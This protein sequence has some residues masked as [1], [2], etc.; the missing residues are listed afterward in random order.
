MSFNRGNSFGVHNDYYT[1]LSAWQDLAKVLRE[2]SVF[3]Q[4]P[5]KR[6][7][8]GDPV[9]PL[10]KLRVW[11]P[12]MLNSNGASKIH[13]ESLGFEVQGNVQ[14]DFFEL[15]SRP[16][17]KSYDLVISNPPFE[18]IRSFKRRHDNLKYKCIKGLLDIG[19]PFVL[20]INSLNVCSRW[21][22]E[23]VRGQEQHIRFIYPAKKIN[24]EKYKPG[25]QEKIHVE[26]NSA[27]FLSIYM[28]F[29]VLLDNTWI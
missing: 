14:T 6:T 17:P 12:F 15:S 9:T 11:E 1:P 22:A 19:K 29:K 10:P 25:G 3:K 8:N 4:S 27:S 18:R 13:L 2:T 20:I 5:A 21:F 16:D 28:C 23:L 24:F 7:A 26:K